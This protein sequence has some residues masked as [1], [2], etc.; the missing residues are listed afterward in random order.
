LDGSA[1]QDLT[2]YI[3]KLGEYPV[4]G[5]GFGEIWRCTYST[6]QGPVT[7]RFQCCFYRPFFKIIISQVAVK[8]VPKYASDQLSKEEKKTHVSILDRTLQVSFTPDI[9]VL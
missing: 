2:E 3:T 4:T 6:D 8:S 7:V 9:A 1:L 5:G